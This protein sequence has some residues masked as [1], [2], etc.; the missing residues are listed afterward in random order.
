MVL[1]Y[2]LFAR[3]TFA[4]IALE[5][6]VAIATVQRIMAHQDIRTTLRYAKVVDASVK[7]GMMMMDEM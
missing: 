2:F 1:R 4:T 3:H 7:K 5:L 6:G